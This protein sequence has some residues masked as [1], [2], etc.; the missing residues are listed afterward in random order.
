MNVQAL[1]TKVFQLSG[2]P[3]DLCPYATWGDPSTF[4]LALGQ[5]GSLP[6]L[7][8]INMAITRIANWEY[9]DGTILRFR[10]L[11]KSFFFKSRVALAGT[12]LSS[13]ADTVTLPGVTTNRANQFSGWII[14]ITGGLG[15][16]QKRIVI[17]DTGATPDVL[18]VHQDWTTQP[19]GTSTFS[20]Y[21]RFFDLVPASVAGTVDD[22][23][24]SRDG[25]EDVADILKLRDITT[26][27]DMGPAPRTELFTATMLGKGLP[28]SFRFEGS[29][30]VFD[31]PFDTSRAFEV[32]YY[33]HPTPLVSSSDPI[34]LSSPFHEAI[35]L[36]AVHSLQMRAQDF[37]GAYATKRDMQELMTTLRNN[38]EMELENEQSGLVVY[39]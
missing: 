24:I 29:R 30:I 28:T 21:K 11:R 20:L 36:W 22:Y 37:N 6:L 27:Q 18:Q 3:S 14:E 9:P 39:A 25:V 33:A 10:H 12:V 38:G 8:W 19:N 4:D 31:T 35:M 34:P 13:T 2:E 7:G 26:L 23:M 32:L 5:T 15:S 17:G 16:G 1:M